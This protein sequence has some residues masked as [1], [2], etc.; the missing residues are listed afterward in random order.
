MSDNFRGMRHPGPASDDR[1]QVSPCR[2]QRT[3][4]SLKPGISVND[5]VARAVH[6]AGADSAYIRLDEVVIE[7]LR[8]VVPAESPDGAHAAWYSETHAPPGAAVT[9]AAGVFLGRRDGRPFT[10]CHGLWQAN[11]SACMG[12]LLTDESKIAVEAQVPAWLVR[13][14]LLNVEDDEETKFRLFSARSQPSPQEEDAPRGLLCTIRPNVDLASSSVSLCRRHGFS[15]AA[16]H[17][18]GSLV[19][20]RLRGSRDIAS[21]VT[22]VLILSGRVSNQLSS[23]HVAA[24]GTDGQFAEGILEGENLVGVT[25][26]LLIAEVKDAGL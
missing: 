5:S 19:G 20:G 18:I 2:V 16:L 7:P 14:A 11:S 22:E 21:F 13:G 15:N 6:D 25:F 9:L 8:Y 24:V 23:L 26:E 1:L 12:H 4:I 10:H 17:G 3:T